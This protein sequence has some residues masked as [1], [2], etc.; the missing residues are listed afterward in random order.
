MNPDEVWVFERHAGPGELAAAPYAKARCVGQDP[1][2]R[3]MYKQGVGMGA[4]WYGGHFD[5]QEE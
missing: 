1:L 5:K 3:A 4:L 2:V